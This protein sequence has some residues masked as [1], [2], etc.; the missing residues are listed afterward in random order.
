MVA[1]EAAGA[2]SVD[3][4]KTSFAVLV[5]A[6]SVDLHKGTLS[7]HFAAPVLGGWDSSYPANFVDRFAVF[8]LT[9]IERNS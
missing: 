5:A 8:K 9:S 6:E 1:F 2:E 4:V 3:V 7:V